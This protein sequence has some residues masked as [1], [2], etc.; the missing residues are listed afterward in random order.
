MV[1]ESDIYQ[2]IIKEH[3]L[4]TFGHVNNATYLEIFEEARWEMITS[5][6]WGLKEIQ[7]SQIGPVILELSMQFLKEI[8]LR[9]VI[10]IETHVTKYEGKVGEI[11]QLMKFEN[12]DVACRLVLKVGLFDLKARKL[13]QP[14]P[15]WFESLG[16]KS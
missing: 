7:K 11:E 15:E 8:R 10:K 16:Q 9:Q 4:D 12:G 6:G 14:T 1:W 13:L 3:H 2:I 5:R